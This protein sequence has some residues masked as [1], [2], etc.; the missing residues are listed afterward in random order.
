MHCHSV[1]S[2]DHGDVRGGTVANEYSTVVYVERQSTKR[3]SST[4]KI[5]IIIIV[6][7]ISSFLLWFVF[8]LV[9]VFLFFVCFVFVFVSDSL[10]GGV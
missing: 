4:K 3:D 2:S 10:P 1:L 5:I 8:V 6:S 9:F 7:L